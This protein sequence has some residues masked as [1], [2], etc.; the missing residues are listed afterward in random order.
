M[1]GEIGADKTQKQNQKST[2]G[3]RQLYKMDRKNKSCK[4]SFPPSEEEGL[5]LEQF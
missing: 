1:R 2:L 4:P 5:E 3:K